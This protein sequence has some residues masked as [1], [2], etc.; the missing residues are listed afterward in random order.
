METDEIKLLDLDQFEIE[1][2]GML[3]ELYFYKN[4]E[5]IHA[6]FSVGSNASRSAFHFFINAYAF[7]NVF[8]Y[9]EAAKKA[10]RLEMGN[11]PDD[12]YINDLSTTPNRYIKTEDINVAIK[13][14]RNVLDVVLQK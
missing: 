9:D 14:C 13:K 7:L 5:D 2:D 6:A 8:P 12:F 1:N 3:A 4:I 10:F 11:V